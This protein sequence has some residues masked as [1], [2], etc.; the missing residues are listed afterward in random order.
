MDV[1]LSHIRLVHH[2]DILIFHLLHVVL[3][4]L[5][6]LL[7]ACKFVRLLCTVGSVLSGGR[8][9]CPQLAPSRP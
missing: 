4:V 3:S 5:C 1:I 8:Q 6:R 9:T 7:L 2:P